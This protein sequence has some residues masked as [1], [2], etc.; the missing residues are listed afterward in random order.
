MAGL[1]GEVEDDRRAL[2]QR[3]QIDLADVAADQI[4][5]RAVQV[6]RVSAAAEQEPVQRRHAC[7]PGGQRVTQVG[8][9][10]PGAAR[11]QHSAT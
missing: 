8:T 7:A 6:A 5:F 3:T 4:D 11:H 2:A 1:R 9:E 10:K